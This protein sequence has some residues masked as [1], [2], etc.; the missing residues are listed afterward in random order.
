MKRRDFLYG[1]P[2]ALGA[3]ALLGRAGNAQAAWLSHFALGA[4]SDEIDPD[5]EKA[6][7][8]LRQFGLGWVEIRDVW[9][10][11]VTDIDSATL[12]RLKG[13]IDSS[14]LRV[15]VVDTALFKTTLPGTHP[16]QGQS[17][18][19]P[20]AVQFDLLKR[21][22]EKAVAL[23]APYLRIFDFWRC[24]E[25]NRIMD[26]VCEHLDRAIEIA[27]PAG[28]R[29]LVENEYSCHT[30][31]GAEMAGLQKKINHPYL[32]FIWDPMN[33]LVAGVDPYPAEYDKLDKARVF[34][35]HIKDAL[36]DPSEGR[37]KAVRVGAGQVDWVGQFRALLVDGFRG[38]LSL[39]TH[40]NGADGTRR[41]ASLESMTSIF[42]L[43]KKA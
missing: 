3:A 32:G 31:T 30:G 29:L 38:T 1:L 23:Q 12:E 19:Y 18:Q 2:A 21:A 24:R 41:S 36:K 10:A 25:Q 42:E 37:Y 6:F 35:V 5:V 28:V 17:D 20:Y 43:I 15:S 7:T 26:E 14:G 22:V 40:Y 4:I 13:V 8:F 33:C 16:D 11:Y 9:G 34:H 39:E 27:R